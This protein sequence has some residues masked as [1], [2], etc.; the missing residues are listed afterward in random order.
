MYL[1]KGIQKINDGKMRDAL[2]FLKKAQVISPDNPEITYFTGIAYSR[3]GNYSEAEA[4]FIKA[5]GMDED[6]LNVYFELGRLYYLT[7][8]C[9]K[10][11][12][13]LLKFKSLSEDESL[14]DYAESLM[15][16]C[17][18]EKTEKPYSLNLSAGAQY[19]SNVIIEPSNPPVSDED[20]SG[21]RALVYLSSGATLLDKGAV[22]LKANYNF[23]QSLH[24][25]LDD[26]NVHYHKVTPFVE[27][28]VSDVFKP[29]AGYSFEYIL[30]GGERYSRIH[31]YY[32]SVDVKESEYLSTEVIYEYSDNR[33]WNSPLFETNDIR[34]GFQNSFGI[35]Q[36]FLLDRLAGDI[37]YY[38]DFNRAEEQYWSFNGYRLGTELVYKITD[39]LFV[40]VSGEYSEK[41]Y[42]DEYPDS[43]L[44]RLDKTQQYSLTLTYLL[45]GTMSVS[46]TEY[47]TR[48][49]SNLG[50][51]DY[52]RNIT[53]IFL[54]IGVL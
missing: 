33:Y 38:G 21:V 4:L 16:T 25:D 43:E 46:V 31:S 22:K 51:F 40:S 24:A 39:P 23:Y 10:S 3:L 17:G 19:D 30:L 14:N 2:A 34:S 9:G 15:E 52:K 1:A 27:L 8:E 20:K 32:G 47:F 29:E 50:I 37:Y 41:D 48:N 45:S 28:A 26:Y 7:S 5:L 36:N 13:F 44:E 42:R 35:K 49:N 6:A 53:G 11:E 18:D 54:T 12:E